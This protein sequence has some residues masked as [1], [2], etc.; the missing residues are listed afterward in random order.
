MYTWIKVY[1]HNRRARIQIDGL[2]SKKVLLRHGVPQGGVL[3][4]TLFL[5]YINDLIA[6]LP[7]GIK[8]AMYADDLV[9]WCT[10]EYA[11]Q[12]PKYYREL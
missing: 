9:M 2:K 11:Q 5:V 1:L 6:K 4:P 12:Q 8:V 3:S 10:E 7:H